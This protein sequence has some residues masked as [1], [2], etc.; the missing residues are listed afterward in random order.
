MSGYSGDAFDALMY[1]GDRD[2][3]GRFGQWLHNG[4]MFTT[5]DQDN[6]KKPNHLTHS[7]C[8]PS[9]GGG[10]WYNNCYKACLTCNRANV[11]WETLSESPNVVNARMMIKPH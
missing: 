7:N 10:W 2:G 5:Y 3:N 9:R 6:D 1:E 11:E 8:A 4:M